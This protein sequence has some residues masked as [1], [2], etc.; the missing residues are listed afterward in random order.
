MT[1]R[2][3]NHSTTEEHHKY[4]RSLSFPEL[5]DYYDSWPDALS[6]PTRL[7]NI[8][9]ANHK[10]FPF[11]TVG[12][13]LDAGEAATTKLMRIQNIGRKT[14]RDLRN[15]VDEV[16]NADTAN[17]SIVQNDNA[18]PITSNEQQE[19]LGGIRFLSFSELLDF[20]DSLPDV[21][22]SPARLRNILRATHKTFP[23]A[24]V[25]KYLDAGDAA[26]SLL[27]SIPNFGKKTERDLRR[28]IGKAMSADIS[29]IVVRQNDK[30]SPVTSS[31]QQ[32]KLDAVRAITFPDLIERSYAS[33]RLKNSIQHEIEK[34][35]FPFSNL[36]EYFDKGG[37]SVLMSIPD[38]GKKTALELP[39]TTSQLTPEKAAGY[40]MGWL[41]R[42]TDEG[43]LEFDRKSIRVP[44]DET[45]K[46]QN[47]RRLADYG[48]LPK[49]RSR[50]SGE[51]SRKTHER[52]QEN[53]EEWCYFHTKLQ[54]Q[55]REW[56]HIPREE[57]IKHIKENLPLGSVVGDF[58]CG[59][60]QLAFALRDE[61]TVHSFDHVAINPS[62][63]ACDM[64][65]TPLDDAILDVAVYCLS[66][67]GAN[68]KDYLVEAY[69]TLK[70]SGQLLVYH[71][72][73][74]AD[75]L[76]FVAGLERLGFAIV[77]QDQLE[78]W[79]YV[80]AI[81]RGRQADAAAEIGF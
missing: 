21:Q 30:V 70:P 67:L 16:M 62:V 54:E 75:R 45:D 72:I 58:G 68:V 49:L 19:K 39:D 33:P 25:G 14:K 11:A 12:D 35:T 50:W 22:P 73:E 1:N 9:L 8:L 59:Q 20:H 29:C 7:R 76:K 66:L 27:M 53:P 2:S 63:V 31:E 10:M 51:Q 17:I 24:S 3:E 46:E 37:I 80:W 57:C 23:F 77:R 65:H 38:F 79:H 48:V 34:G 55:E 18:T 28:I 32:E 26:T 60:A 15:L 56:Q 43:M 74:N 42:L 41:K 78:K 69:R 64:A 36:G 52:L 44:L 5:L 81:K 4:V 61:Y 47:Q 6:V 13:Y 40:W 71:P